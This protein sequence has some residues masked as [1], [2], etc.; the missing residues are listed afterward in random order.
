MNDQPT[1]PLWSGRSE[2]VE[3]LLAQQCELCGSSDNIVVHHPRKLA[4]LSAKGQP[5]PPDWKKRMAARRRKTLVVCRTCHER[6]HGGQYDGKA[7]KRSDY[8]RAT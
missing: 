4:D 6:I 2:V 7:V 1:K 5:E 3:R 8:W